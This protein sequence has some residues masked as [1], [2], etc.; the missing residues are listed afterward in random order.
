[1]ISCA[2]ASAEN[3]TTA[4]T[5]ASPGNFRMVI[6]LPAQSLARAT[7]GARAA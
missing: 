7:F 1:L 5:A 3:P 6:F 4:A 2:P